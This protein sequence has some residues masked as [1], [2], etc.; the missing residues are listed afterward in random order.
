MVIFSARGVALAAAMCGVVLVA[1]PVSAEPTPSPAPTRATPSGV[2][3]V[4]ATD[5]KHV[6][7]KGQ[8]LDFGLVNP[9]G[10][11]SDHVVVR[12]VGDAPTTVKL[13][14]ADANT[15]VG[16]GLAFGLSTDP[17]K[18]L[19]AWMHL[20]QTQ[21]SVGPR[22]S[23]PLDL[24]ITLPNPVQGGEYAG[25]I[26]A[27]EVRADSSTGGTGLR[28]V[29]R[30]AMPVYLK[31]PGGV[32]GSTPGRGQPDGTVTLPK[33][34]FHPKGSDKVCFDATYR[35]GS[36]DV[37]NPDVTITTRA[38]WFGTSKTYV[39]KGIGAATPDATVTTHLPCVKLPVTGG[40]VDVKIAGPHVDPLQN[41]RSREF[42]RTPATVVSAFVL[43]LVLLLLLLLVLLRRWLRR[44]R[45]A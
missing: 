18:Q 26:V 23:V 33:V 2:A 17:K 37:V 8:S 36:Q 16:G 4:P 30:F 5:S 15:A 44:S 11:V 21:V 7:G 24:T 22:G 25:G 19:G 29:Y 38:R 9:G 31:V 10:T 20:S 34:E 14:A 6:S 1:S 3:I 32:P 42:D 27:E 41:H 28:Q 45:R 40:K 12:N 13:Y 35:N 43:V 39:F